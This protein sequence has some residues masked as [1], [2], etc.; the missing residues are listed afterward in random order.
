MS[1]LLLGLVRKGPTWTPEATEEILENQRR[2]LALLQRLSEEGKLLL[3][4]PIPDGE[5]LR[6][7]VIC[8]AD[9]A[10]EARSWFDADA[11]VQSGRLRLDFH[12]WLVPSEAAQRLEPPG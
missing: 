11:H 3:S 8:R 2:H 7:I 5:E 4:G 10:A 1:H 9:S 12:G 6:G